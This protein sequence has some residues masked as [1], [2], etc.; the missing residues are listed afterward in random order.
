MVTIG[1]GYENFVIENKMTDLVNTLL[2]ARSLMTIDYSLAEQ[3]GLKKVVN[4]Y[5]YTGKVEKLAKGAKNT[6]KGAVSFVPKEYVVER[7]Q[8]TYGYNDM[9]LMQDPYLLDVA[10]TGA[11]TII[12]NDIKTKYFDEVAKISNRFNFDTF[13]Y[14]TIVDALAEL[15]KEVETDMF[16]I[17]GG[18][19]KAA[20]RKD[21]DFIASKQGEILYT[22]Q[23]GTICGIPVIFSKLVPK[24]TCYITKKDAV[25]FFVKKEGSVEQDRDIETKDNVVVYERHGL[26]ALVDDTYSSIITKTMP[27]LTVEL[28]AGSGK[29]TLAAQTAATGYKFMYRVTETEATVPFL[30]STDTEGYVEYSANTDIAATK[31]QYVQV[32]KVKKSTGAIEAFGQAS[33]A[34]T[35]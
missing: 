25:K 10:S 27:A 1:T 7:Y 9:D 19:L 12:A 21:K 15:N 16:I 28:T 23:F 22:G 3:A 13:S 14:D 32:I 8:H 11:S 20:I 4:K 35:A 5:T 2:E 30:E 29:I 33:K 24:N 34:P 6:V 31:E 17:M 26:I 18:D